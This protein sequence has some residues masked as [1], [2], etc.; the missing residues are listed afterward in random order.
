MHVIMKR[1]DQ[2]IEVKTDKMWHYKCK[3]K[4]N[5]SY[6]NMRCDDVIV[7]EGTSLYVLYVM[8][9]LYVL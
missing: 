1:T 4:T 2:S 6:K 3:S 9:V 5:F 7:T 8:Y